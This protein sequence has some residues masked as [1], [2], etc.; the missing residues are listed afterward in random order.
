M[1]KEFQLRTKNED[2]EDSIA[3]LN[4]SAKTFYSNQLMFSDYDYDMY[5]KS[6]LLMAM[7]DIEGTIKGSFDCDLSLSNAN[8]T[9]LKTMFPI[10]CKVLNI[11]TDEDVFK[12]GDILS[13][14]R[15]INAHSTISSSNLKHLLKIEIDWGDIEPINKNINLV[16]DNGNKTVACIVMLIMLFL[17]KESI[18][19]LC[20]ASFI[21]SLLACGSFAPDNGETFVNKINKVNL[22]TPIRHKIGNN[23][24]S[25]IFGEYENK[26]IDL[27]KN[28]YNLT[29]SNGESV[30]YK[31]SFLFDGVDKLV[32]KDD[33]LTKV[34][35]D[36]NYSLSIIDKNGF[37]ELS[38]KMPPFVLIDLLYKLEITVFTKEIYHKLVTNDRY[39]KLNY[40]K[41]YIDKNIDTLIA[42]SSLADL[43]IVSSSITSSLNSIL[44][45]FEKATFK[46]YGY[47][48]SDNNYSRIKDAF[49]LVGFDNDLKWH[50]IILRNFAMHN[51]LLNEHAFLD[52]FS[53]KYDIDFIINTLVSMEKHL[54]NI[55][56]KLFN[57]FANDVRALFTERLIAVKYKKIVE[58]TLDVFDGNKR[59]NPYSQEV[60]N[61]FLNIKSSIYDILVLNKLFI[62]QQPKLYILEYIING[63]ERPLYIN[64]FAYQHE[65]LNNYLN[66]NGTFITVDVKDKGIIKTIYL[67][68]TN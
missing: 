7:N 64:N 9:M 48:I 44:L 20:K 34:Y 35:Y 46:C 51:Y 26:L 43:R 67:E 66:S 12:L 62:D 39:L 41:F 33:S 8:T 1:K 50:A 55:D 61:K 58:Y 18:E 36:S 54:L 52:G 2:R 30:F 37:I 45:R 47:H 13:L 19:K 28:E 14:L 59:F 40:P 56:K 53:Y 17:R 57:K 38:N 23:L 29:I 15:N 49:D 65:L 25:S 24:L 4:V 63:Q 11:N 27:G 10:G 68:K 6:A 3:F 16:N 21:F 31:L 22:E 60:I 42:S 5:F 32:V